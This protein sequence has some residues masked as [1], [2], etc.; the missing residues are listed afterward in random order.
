MSLVIVAAI[1]TKSQWLSLG[2]METVYESIED[3]LNYLS[4]MS[5]KIS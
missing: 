5:L 2:K 4:F 1:H 3:Y